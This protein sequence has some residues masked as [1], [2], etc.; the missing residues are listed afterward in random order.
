MLLYLFHKCLILI[1]FTPLTLF[2]DKEESVLTWQYK[3]KS[4]L[5]KPQIIAEKV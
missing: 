1:K 3:A 5:R 2:N 4:Y